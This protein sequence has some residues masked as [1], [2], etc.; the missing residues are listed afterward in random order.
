MGVWGAHGEVRQ[1]RATA[2]PGFTYRGNG[3]PVKA[4]KVLFVVEVFIN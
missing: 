3:I 2:G 4:P 1:G